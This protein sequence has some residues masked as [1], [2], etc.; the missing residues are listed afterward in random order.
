M[1]YE[2]RTKMAPL[3]VIAIFV[4]GSLCFMACGGDVNGDSAN[5]PD[6]HVGEAAEG[7][8]VGGS[9]T[10][11]VSGHLCNTGLTC[12]IPSVWPPAFWGTCRDL[13][14]DPNNCGGCGTA[15]GAPTHGTAACTNGACG[16]TC[17][18]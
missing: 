16:Y 4:F 2:K 7:V 15:C 5:D 6:E 17:D 18:S 1:S 3:R 10:Y 14:N 8:S 12:C 13:N 9:C 11:I